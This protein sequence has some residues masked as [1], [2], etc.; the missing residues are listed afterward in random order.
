MSNHEYHQYYMEAMKK[1]AGN[2]KHKDWCA[3]WKGG[4]CNCDPTISA[5]DVS[6]H[7]REH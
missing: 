2:R 7:E 1:L 4:A 3:H 6:P 5:E